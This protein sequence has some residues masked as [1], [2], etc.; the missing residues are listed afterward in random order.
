MQEVK[1]VMESYNN[2]LGN[3]SKG[4]FY[5]SEQLRE[6]SV[7]EAL[8]TILNFSEGMLWLTEAS[9][10]L[11]KN[12]VKAKINIEKI[13]EFLIEVNNGL[14]KQDYVLV[15][16]MFEYEIAPFFEEVTFAVG[17]DKNDELESN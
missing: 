2:Y 4:A 9:E 17:P 6:D 7:Q 15:A 14:E 8:S 3:V 11:E 16:D 12:N 5:I 13:Q 1:E 10:L